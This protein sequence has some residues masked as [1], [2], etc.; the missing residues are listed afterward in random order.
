MSERVVFEAWA[1]LRD[2]FGGLMSFGD[3]RI[4][5]HDQAGARRASS[6]Y[7]LEPVRVRVTVE[8]I[9]REKGEEG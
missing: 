5:L 1:I 9:E 6:A 7:G 8:I 4:D 3:I 2:D